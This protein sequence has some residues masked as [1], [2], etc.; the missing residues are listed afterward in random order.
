MFDEERFRFTFDPMPEALDPSLIGELDITKVLSRHG[1]VH[2]KFG[3]AIDRAILLRAGKTVASIALPQSA[4]RI[5]P[6]P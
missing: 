4:D 2:V 3:R 5:L 6:E 1:R